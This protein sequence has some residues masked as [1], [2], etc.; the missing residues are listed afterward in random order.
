MNT[1]PHKLY[2]RPTSTTAVII[3]AQLH[4]SLWLKDLLADLLQQIISTS[5]DTSSWVIFIGCNDGSPETWKK[6]KAS[7]DDWP[8]LHWLHW[9]SPLSPPIAR[10]LLVAQAISYQP[11][12]LLF[13]D[14]DVMIPQSFVL[15]LENL[16]H[17]TASRVQFIGGPQ[18]TPPEQMKISFIQAQNF[19][20]KEPSITAQ[21]SGRYGGKAFITHPARNLEL[22]VTLCNL[23]VRTKSFK[24]F[25]PDLP[26]GEELWLL[27][28]IGERLGTFETTFYVYHRRRETLFSLWQQMFRSGHGRGLAHKLAPRSRDYAIFI[29]LLM[30]VITSLNWPCISLGILAVLQFYWQKKYWYQNKHFNWHLLYLPYVMGLGYFIG[31]SKGLAY[32]MKKKR[33]K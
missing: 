6:V 8:H 33:H 4:R 3:V 1:F 32:N 29:G 28:Q 12:W 22:Q 31:L 21:F 17:L 20:L 14:D 7:I 24:E 26:F 25:P 5:K 11:E 30:I 13:L 18:M 27:R 16:L 9:P 23:L 10:N 2:K 15:N 19:C